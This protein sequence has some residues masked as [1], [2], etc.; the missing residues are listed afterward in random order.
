MGGGILQLGILSVCIFVPVWLG[1]YYSGLLDKLK[2]GY[3]QTW[4]KDAIGVPSYVNEVKGHVMYQGQGSY[5]VKLGGK[6][7]FLLFVSLLKSLIGTKLGQD[8][9]G[10]PLYDNEVK[11]HVPRSRVI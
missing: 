4:V 1:F 11:G 7:W 9:I 3:Y 10:V 2:S 6:S 8:A 5:E